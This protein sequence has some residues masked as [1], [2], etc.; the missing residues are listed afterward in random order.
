MFC[1]IDVL[2][3]LFEFLNLHRNVLQVNSELLGKTLR[4]SVYAKICL[5]HHTLLYGNSDSA[6]SDCGE[7][8]IF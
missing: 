6:L 5:K 3:E 1:K 8:H 4:V 2:I 7:N